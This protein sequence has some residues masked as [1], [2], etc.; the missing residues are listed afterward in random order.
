MLEH[1]PALFF[2]IP[3][4]EYQHENSKLRG[5]PVKRFEVTACILPD[6]LPFTCLGQESKSLLLLHQKGTGGVEVY[7]FRVGPSFRL[8]AYCQSLIKHKGLNI[9]TQRVNHIGG[10]HG[11]FVFH[12]PYE[13]TT[14]SDSAKPQTLE[15]A[16]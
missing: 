14:V 6:G 7:D 16:A 5:T 9:E 8:P 1:L 10:W 13:I 4:E 2:S 3:I 11:R 12:T 15:G